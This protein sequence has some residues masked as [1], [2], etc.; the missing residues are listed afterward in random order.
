MFQFLVAKQQ[1]D[2]K[3]STKK[4]HH[5]LVT[6]ITYWWQSILTINIQQQQKHSNNHHQQAATSEYSLNS[7][8]PFKC[9]FLQVY[10]QKDK[11]IKINPEELELSNR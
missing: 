10:K 4:H 11:G 6:F 9:T 7:K 5:E 1:T 3:N 2:V 8:Q